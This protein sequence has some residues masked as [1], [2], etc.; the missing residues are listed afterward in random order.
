MRLSA[1]AD[2]VPECGTVADIGCDHGKLA[3]ALVQ[4]DCI[5][6]DCNFG[7]SL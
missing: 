6:S 7:G 4:S 1:I 5:T 2:M 3:V